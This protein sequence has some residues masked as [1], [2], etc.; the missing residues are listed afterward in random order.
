M[1]NIKVLSLA[2]KYH[3]AVTSGVG[4]ACEGLN[5]ALSK[6]VDLT[7]IQP[8]IKKVTIE[9]EVLLSGE[10]LTEEQRELI[11]EEYVEISEDGNIQLAIALDPY[12]P[13]DQ[14]ISGLEESKTSEV[15][16]RRPV[17]NIKQVKKRGEDR[18]IKRYREEKLYDDVDVFGEHVQDKI[19]LYNRLVE[20][21]AHTIQFDV[22]HA[23]DW[24][25]FQAGLRLKEQYHKPLV[26]HVHSLEFDR[27]GHKDVAWV[28]DIERFALSKADA[29]VA[30]SDYTK[31]IIESNYG[32]YSA[33]IHT[34]YNAF[35][36]VSSV[37]KK[38]ASLTGNNKILFAGRIHEN[39]GLEYFIRIAKQTLTK[40]K[41]ATFIVVGR[42]VNHFNPEQ[43]E[44]FKE[45][46]DKFHFI[47][48]VER[49]ELF[50]LYESCD[51]LC[52][53][54]ISEPFGLTALEAAHVGLPV[55]LSTKSG[56]SEI[57]P[58]APKANFWDTEK[59][60]GFIISLLQDDNRRRR[61]IATNKKAASELSWDMAA[62][63]VQKIY[64]GI[65]P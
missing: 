36:P 1:E 37:N 19:Y 40:V 18:K 38:Y 22:I 31:G 51:V 59:F 49:E 30:V 33:K 7:V 16:K 44:G 14:S 3:P 27:V 42:G 20:E 10:D 65:I 53:P 45:V 55:I 41:D 35:S 23:H 43:V 13:E 4:V 56:I 64:K 48:F 17:E 24:M 12:Y 15:T 28:Y 26:L 62:A 46:A 34:V 5:N 57:L 61:L 9:E 50:G 25:T 52:M 11:W 21:L 39:K 60:S 2:W 8:T 29:V 54:S 32:L 6:L 63:A 47:G 58:R